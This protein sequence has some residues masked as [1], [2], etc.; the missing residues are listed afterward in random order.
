MLLLFPLVLGV[1]RPS[2][3]SELLELQIAL[4]LKPPC[5]WQV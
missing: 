4:S 2:H 5:Y 3:F 1:I